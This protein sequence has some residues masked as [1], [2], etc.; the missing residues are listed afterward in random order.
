MAFAIV[1]S[2]NVVKYP[3]T[4][5]DVKRRFSNVSFSSEPTAEDL[6]PFGV[7]DVAKVSVP[8]YD[9]NTQSVAEG[10]PQLVGETYT[11][12]WI[13]SNLPADEVAERLAARALSARSKRNVLLQSCDWIVTMHKEL[14]TNIPAAWKTY[15]QE[16]RD[17]PSQAGFPD[18]ITWPTE[19]S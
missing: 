7:F 18:S 11:Q 9:E 1:E 13:I 17:V 10:T 16:L 3:A 2:G 14:G 4:L 15:R 8:S 12:Q 6:S 19:P 5:G